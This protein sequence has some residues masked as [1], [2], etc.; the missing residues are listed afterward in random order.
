VPPPERTGGVRT[1][2]LVSGSMPVLGRRL[3]SGRLMFRSRVVMSGTAFGRGEYKILMYPCIGGAQTAC[4]FIPRLH[5]SQTL[6]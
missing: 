4:D 2:R 5:P 3:L 6:D 1:E